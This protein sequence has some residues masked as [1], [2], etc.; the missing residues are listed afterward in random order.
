MTSPVVV[1]LH[2][3]AWAD[4]YQAVSLALTAAALGDEVT[5]AL[6]FEPLRLWAA[7]RFDEGGPPEAAGVGIPSLREALDEG[8]RELGVR[9]VACDTALRL[10]GLTPEAAGATLDGV[11][12]LPALWQRGRRGRALVI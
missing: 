12:A 5:I 1:F 9:V 7:G 10:A 6:F 4:R 3:G 8:R 11:E 2:R